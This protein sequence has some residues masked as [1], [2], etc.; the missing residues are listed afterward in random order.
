[1]RP[2]SAVKAF[3]NKFPY[4]AYDIISLEDLNNLTFQNKLYKITKRYLKKG[5]VLDAGCGT[6]ELALL[7]ASRGFKSFGIDNSEESLR[8]ARNTSRQ[9]LLP[10]TFKIMD[11]LN[12]KFPKNSFDAVIANG[13]LHHTNDPNL[14]FKNLLKITKP[15]GII[16]VVVYNKL[17][18]TPRKLLGKAARLLGGNS[19]D[20]QIKW[21]K[22]YLPKRYKNKPDSVIADAFFNPYET[23]FGISE[24]LNWF[25]NER[26]KYLESS[27]SIE[28]GRYLSYLLVEIT[29]MLSF[30][31][32]VF[33]MVGRKLKT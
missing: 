21:L 26:V 4:P 11:V 7:F 29:W 14:G 6:G 12:V 8:I 20:T 30:T 9:L 27:P 17:G 10:A 23:A 16:L 25:K 5:K 31:G 24:I 18:S 2:D 13:V 19:I 15:G 28:A 3:Y 33:I 22:K 1:M 32:N